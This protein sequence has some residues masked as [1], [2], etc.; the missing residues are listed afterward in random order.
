MELRF[1]H[2][3]TAVNEESYVDTISINGT[4]AG[5]SALNVTRFDS[6]ILLGPQDESELLYNDSSNRLHIGNQD[7]P[8]NLTMYSPDGSDWNCGVNNAGTFSCS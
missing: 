1:E 7:N 6:S 3:A 8:T 4:L 2:Q 5:A